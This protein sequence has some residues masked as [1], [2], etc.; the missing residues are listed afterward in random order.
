MR[1]HSDRRILAVALVAL[2]LATAVAAQQDYPWFR[3]RFRGPEPRLPTPASFDGYFNFCRG[4]FY[5][6]RREYGGQGWWTDYPAADVNFSIRLSELTKTR[7]SRTGDREPNHLVVRLT[8]DEL[9][10]CPF[11]EMEDVGTARFSDEEVLRLRQYLLKGGFLWVDDFWG[12]WAWSQW[13]EEIQRVLPK[14]DYPIRPIDTDHAVFRTFFQVPRLPQIP[15]IAHWR[16]TGGETSERGEE[17]AVPQ[18]YAISDA[19]DRIMVLMTHNTDISDAWEREGEDPR[20]FYL[21]SP[22]GYSVGINVL[23]YTMTH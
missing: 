4:M 13:V 11:I 17:S 23:M 20:F 3:G 9:F 8:D 5:S 6:D 18:M 7:V 14:K 21:F 15:S 1:R 22:N 10:K 16:R 2:A 19:H 12:D